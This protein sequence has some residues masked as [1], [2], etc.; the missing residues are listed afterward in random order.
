MNEKD[1]IIELQKEVIEGLK[2]ELTVACHCGNTIID[3]CKKLRKSNQIHKQCT[4]YYIGLG[5][6]IGMIICYLVD[7][8]NDKKIDKIVGDSE[9]N[10]CNEEV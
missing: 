2:K 1:T 8:Y 9:E 7:M 5:V 3:E 4:K 10:Q 6:G